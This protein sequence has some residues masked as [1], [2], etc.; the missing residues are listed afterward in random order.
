V[1]PAQTDI[2]LPVDAAAVPVRRERPARSRRAPRGRRGGPSPRSR[3]LVAR[4][5]SPRTRGWSHREV[6]L[7]GAG[8]SLAAD[9][10]DP[11]NW[12]LYRTR[13]PTCSPRD[14]LGRGLPRAGHRLG[15]PPMGRRAR[16][17]DSSKPPSWVQ[18]WSAS[19]GGTPWPPGPDRRG[20]RPRCPGSLWAFGRTPGRSL[21]GPTRGSTIEGRH[22]SGPEQRSHGR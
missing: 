15:R 2:V 10:C 19:L 4:M 6:V 8:E 11:A 12:V 20:R 22:P 5:C 13:R 14:C 9:A 18:E 16:R 3:F 21:T 7:G 17:T 1:L